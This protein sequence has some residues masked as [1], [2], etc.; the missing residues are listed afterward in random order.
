[1]RRPRAFTLI[2]VLVVMGIITIL[3]ALLFP[4][5]TQARER[6]RAAACLSNCRQI[7][8]AVGMYVQDYDSYF[9]VQPGDGMRVMAAGGRLPTYYDALMPYCRNR[10]IWLCPSGEGP[11]T[12]PNMGYHLNGNLVTAHGLPEAAVAAPSNCLLMREFGAGLDQ[13]VAWLRPHRGGCDD[14]F[15][16][17]SHQVWR[18]K[19]KAGPHLG[20]YN[21]LLTDT[22]ARWMRPEAAIDLAHFPEDL[23]KSTWVRHPNAYPRCFD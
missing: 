6:V 13:P 20:G 14:T 7:G 4:V 16:S 18:W 15:I 3:A 9:P 21:F 10:Q 23:G 22:H 19:G 2:E 12:P 1:M 11:L 17:A 8:F 5:F